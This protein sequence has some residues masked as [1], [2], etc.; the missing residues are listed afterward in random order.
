MK[1]FLVR[2]STRI[3]DQI[4]KAANPV[5]RVIGLLG[6]SGLDQGQGLLLV[7]CNSIH[8]VGMRYAID[9]IY[10]DAKNSIIKICEHLQPNRLGALVWKAHSVL[11]V[12]AGFARENSLRDG[13]QLQFC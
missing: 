2:N 4:K 8:T 11:E 10:L 5:S 3:A 13:D 1:L 6:T 9:A 7:G 12:P